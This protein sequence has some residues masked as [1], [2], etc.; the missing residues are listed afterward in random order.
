MQ[1]DCGNAGMVR[2]GTLSH[3]DRRR[4][5]VMAIVIGGAIG[6]AVRAGLGEGLSPGAWPWATLVA[7]IS[8][9]IL[10]AV[11][12]ALMYFRPQLPHWLHPLIAVGFCGS[13]TTFSGLEVEAL[14]MMQH[15][16]S[17]AAVAYM[18][19]SVVLG[20]VAAVVGRRAIGLVHA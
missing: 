2:A 20:L 3:V 16:R 4:A 10:L 14:L 19:T 6:A 7:N 15:G 11:L 9:T 13:L 1:G 8:G 5:I 17:G 18:L 12:A